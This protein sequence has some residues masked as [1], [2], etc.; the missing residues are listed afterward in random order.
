ME[1]CWAHETLRDSA[2]L[3]RTLNSDEVLRHR[4][5]CD[6]D[7]GRWELSQLWGVVGKLDREAR[8]AAGAGA[9]KPDGPADSDSEAVKDD[10]DVAVAEADR[11]HPADRLARDPLC[12][13]GQV[14]R[15]SVEYLLA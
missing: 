5:F 9:S 10:N 4:W 2:A 11:L 1:A 3:A 12:H 8:V 14:V 7:A 6:G 13:L 15:I